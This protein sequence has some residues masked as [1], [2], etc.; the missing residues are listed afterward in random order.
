MMPACESHPNI[1][2]RWSYISGEGSGALFV[3]TSLR[4]APPGEHALEVCDSS[5]PGSQMPRDTFRG[6]TRF[7]ILLLRCLQEAVACC[8]ESMAGV[9]ETRSW[10]RQVNVS[11]TSL[12]DNP[13]SGILN[14]VLTFIMI[15]RVCNDCR[16]EW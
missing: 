7:V 8:W 6:T 13:D 9:L 2:L 11:S 14:I 10:M 16:H 1:R 5:A 12:V 15:T 4:G 3:S